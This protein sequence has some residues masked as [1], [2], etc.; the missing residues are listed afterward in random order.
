MHATNAAAAYA[1]VSSSILGTRDIEQRVFRQTNGRLMAV[2]DDPDAPFTDMAE[3]VHVNTKLWTMLAVDVFSDENTMPE[4]LR[5]Q[6]ASLA[7][8]A[9][10]TGRAVLRRETPVDELIDLNNTIIAGLDGDTGI[11]PGGVQ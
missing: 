6:I 2:R 1:T 5:A 7:L 4:T 3:A 9:Q 11:A 8:Y 10:K